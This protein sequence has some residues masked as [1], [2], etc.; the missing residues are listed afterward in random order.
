MS[1]TLAL[2]APA[3]PLE[4]EERLRRSERL[5][6]EETDAATRAAAL[7]ELCFLLY[8]SDNERALDYAEEARRLARRQRLRAAE[9]DSLMNIARCRTAR[10]ENR[11]ALSL[12]KQALAS[13]RALGDV[14]AQVSALNGC[15]YSYAQLSS[16]RHALQYFR[17]AEAFAQSLKD[18]HKAGSLYGNFAYVFQQLHDLPRALEYQQKSL[19][20]AEQTGDE[21]L[22]A[23]TLA[24]IGTTHNRMWSFELAI[25]YY[26]AAVESFRSCGDDV[27]I[28]GCQF[29]KGT[30]LIDWN[31]PQEALACFEECEAGYHAIGNTWMEARTVMHKAIVKID[32]GRY[33]EAEADLDVAV[34]LSAG[35]EM[36]LEAGISRARGRLLLYSGR[37]Q[38]AWSELQNALALAEARREKEQLC[39]IHMMLADVAEKQG[40]T[41]DALAHRKCMQS[42]Q[43]EQNAGADLAKMTAMETRLAVCES[44][45]ETADLQRHLERMKEELLSKQQDLAETSLQLLQMH[46][47]LGRIDAG[48]QK[49]AAGT[50]RQRSR[51][52]D[53]L[54]SVIRRTISGDEVVESPD[55]RFIDQHQE[56]MTLLARRFPALTPMERKICALIRLDLSAAAIAEMLVM[57]VKTV[58]THRQRIR[59]KLEISS[60]GNLSSW[61]SS[62]D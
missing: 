25:R 55:Q 19:L 45:R 41:A 9:F 18:Q 4:A 30:I 10:G 40:R 20:I 42:I 50:P 58:Y 23:S 14:S 61:L 3:N 33:D 36:N 17:K 38:E 47:L 13:A 29:N 57:S 16:F 35:Q 26:A 59:R 28:L 56:F 15:G 12:Y 46:E 54:R 21:L 5:L 62:L 37:L 1:S 44:E 22:K 52:V 39:D 7:N 31:R 2:V 48:L 34:A 51:G 53:N 60:Y 6:Q 11:R 27:G 8:R 32:L 24:N 49:I 43:D